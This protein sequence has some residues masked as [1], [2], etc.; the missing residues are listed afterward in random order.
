M[1]KIIASANQ[2]NSCYF[3]TSVLAPYR[4]ALVQITEQ[5]NLHCFVSAGEYGD[6]MKIENI[7]RILIPRLQECRV[8]SVTLVGGEPFIHPDFIEIVSL[9]RKAD[10][11]VG[12]CTNATLIKKVV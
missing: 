8:V 5:C 3:R 1:K 2:A 4:K 11:K 10:M 7:R 6:T 9:F 12:I